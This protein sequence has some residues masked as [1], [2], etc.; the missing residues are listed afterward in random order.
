[1]SDADNAAQRQIADGG[2]AV[3]QGS[4]AQENIQVV[5]DNEGPDEILETLKRQLQEM[6]ARDADRAKELEAEQKRRVEAE[7]AARQAAERATRAT[8]QAQQAQQES[9]RSTTA[10]HL[11]AVKN[12]LDAHAGQMLALE[13]EHAKAMSEG[14]FDAAAKVQSKMAVLGGKIAQLESGRA[15][16]EERIKAAPAAGAQQQQQ[17]PATEYERREAYIQRYTPVVQTWLRG[18]HGD[19]FFRD[20]SFQR[21]V[22]GAASYAE[23]NRGLDPNSQ[24][25]IEFIESEVGLREARD[26]GGDGQQQQRGRDAEPNANP[27]G[28][29]RMTTAPAGG[30]TGGAVRSNPDGS[31]TVRLTRAEMELA[32]SQGVTH[33]EWARHKRALTNEGLI[34]PSARR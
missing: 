11:D 31:T 26:Q 1:M 2:A 24:A 29:R 22:M 33:A 17:P 4:R 7:S 30:A 13:A 16:L 32:D 18:Q 10:A 15:E 8:T 23:N 3:D 5:E 9:A 25:Y 19:R 12:S 21:K 28:N 14:E 6:E 27:D 34:G 20:E